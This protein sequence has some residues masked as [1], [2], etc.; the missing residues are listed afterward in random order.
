MTIIRV[1]DFE[2]TGLLPTSE[3]CEVD[4]CDFFL[5]DKKVG[6]PKSW[7]CKVKSMPPD[8][9]A[10]HHISFNDCNKYDIFNS[11]M[12]YDQEVRVIAAHNAAFELQFFNPLLPIICTYKSALRVWPNAPSHSNGVLRYWLEDQGLIYPKHDLTQPAHRAGPD[13]YVTSYILM[14]LFNSGVTG[15]SMVAWTK[16]P[17]F[18]PV[19]TIGKFKGKPWF[20]VDGGFF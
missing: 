5:E 15:R 20:E 10:I 3:V 16:E 1:I 14:A 8:A 11:N 17:A 2:T 4:L 7:L 9:R 13:A 18:L 19:C 12:L 6:E